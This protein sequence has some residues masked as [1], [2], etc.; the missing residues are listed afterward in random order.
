MNTKLPPSKY[1]PFMEMRNPDFEVQ[2]VLDE[3]PPEVAL[4][5]HIFYELYL[6]C[7]GEIDT[8][9]VDNNSYSLK[10]GDILIIPPEVMHHPIFSTRNSSYKR[11]VL[12]ISQP[13]FEKMCLL[14][15]EL[16][17]VF[18]QCRKSRNYLIRFKKPAHY[19]MLEDRLL[20]MREDEDPDKALCSKAMNFLKCVEFIA[21]L[22]RSAAALPTVG[23]R[24]NEERSLLE[25]IIAYVSEN[26]QRQISLAE[27]AAHFFVSP[28]SIEN[29]FKQ[30]LGKSFYRYVI[31]YR[32]VSAQSL[33]ARG[34]P[35]K[36]VSNQCGFTDYSTFFKM[37]KKEVGVSPSNFQVLA[38]A[39]INEAIE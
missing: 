5:A 29:L 2:Y 12:Y 14:D 28:S 24:I 31:E 34:T 22:N 10:P 15:P 6:F 30:K 13:F 20:N 4:H 36:D 7:S 38:A 25:Q 8:Y 27:T 19:R 1:D 21:H 9:M 23:S 35:L 18:E 39:T 37:F 33:I 17:V 26:Y 11:Y 3:K 32:I 16:G